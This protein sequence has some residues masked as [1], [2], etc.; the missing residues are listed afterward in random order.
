MPLTCPRCGGD[1]E[2]RQTRPPANGTLFSCPYCS[3]TLYRQ[4]GFCLSYELIPKLLEPADAKRILRRWFYE[5][6]DKL[7]AVDE[8]QFRYI[9]F[10]VITDEAGERKAT[11]AIAL[12]PGSP[13][14]HLPEGPREPITKETAAKN[15]WPEP[16]VS[17]ED[18][19]QDKPV[20]EALLVWAP[21]YWITYKGKRKKETAWVE[22][23]LGKV[24]LD[25]AKITADADSSEK[26]GWRSLLRDFQFTIIFIVILFI[27][28][29]SL[30][31]LTK[32]NPT[33]AL[34]LVL[35]ALL[36]GI[37]VLHRW[38]QKL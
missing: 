32:N 18:L 23:F 27:F 9:P 17:L 19:R 8:P 12:P 13:L 28:S 34:I 24:G 6:L 5:K 36:A 16:T 10:W 20:Q 29:T 38:R 2:S 7:P 22:A 4:Q 14:P 31:Y 21:F 35:G 33:G 26:V 30:I 11:P 15:N 1:V 3:S 37:F 25:L